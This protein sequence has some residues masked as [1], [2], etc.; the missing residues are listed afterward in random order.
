MGEGIFS[1]LM[2]NLG[3]LGG[4]AMSGLQGLFSPAAATGAGGAGAGILTGA[5]SNAA[6]PLMS[7]VGDASLAMNPQSLVP[8][9][10]T[11]GSGGIFSILGDPNLQGALQTG[12]GIFKGI[13]DYR[14]GNTAMDAIN[15]SNA[16]AEDAYRRDVEADERRQ[17][18]QW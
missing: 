18:L 4:N 12:G 7:A 15:A 10:T 3:N 9:A 13:Q 1:S 8:A 5:T 17:A 16:R 2:S 11:G 6:S 14:A